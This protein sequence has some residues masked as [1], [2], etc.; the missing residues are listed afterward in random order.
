[1]QFTLPSLPPVSF[2][3]STSLLHTIPEIPLNDNNDDEN[4]PKI[5]KQNSSTATFEVGK[6]TI[7]AISPLACII[8]CTFAEI[9]F[10]P[11]QIGRIRI[12]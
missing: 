3:S 7:I 5:K 9:H 2:L 10:K 12:I 11:T 8:V 6:I 1:V 4:D